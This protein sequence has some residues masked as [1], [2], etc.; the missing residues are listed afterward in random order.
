ME[1]GLRE[2]VLEL[3]QERERITKKLQ[4]I[5]FDIEEKDGN[6][7]RGIKPRDIAY[8]QILRTRLGVVI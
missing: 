6:V 2:E 3:L 7:A 5:A 8:K 4:K 1:S